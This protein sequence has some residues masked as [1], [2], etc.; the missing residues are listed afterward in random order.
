[1]GQGGG[2][3]DRILPRRPQ[4]RPFYGGI[5]RRS[6]GRYGRP[7]FPPA[8]ARTLADLCEDPPRRGRASRPSSSRVGSRPACPPTRR[9]DGEGASSTPTPLAAERLATCEATTRP[10]WGGFGRQPKFPNAACLEVLMPSEQVRWDQ[11]TQELLLTLEKMWRGGIYDHLRG[12][13]AR[14]AVDQRVAGAALREDAVRQRAAAGACTPDASLRWPEPRLPAP[15]RARDRRATSRADMRGPAGTF[16]AATDAD[17]EGVEGKYFCWTPAQLEAV[18]GSRDDAA[19]FAAVYGV[20]PRGN[21]EHGMSILHLAQPPDDVADGL[22]MTEAALEARLAPLRAKLLAARYQRVPPLRDDKILT[23]W[24]GL[25]ISGFVRAP[26]GGRAVGRARSW[27]GAASPSPTAG[28]GACSPRTSARHGDVMRVD[29]GGDVHTRGYL[30]DLAFLARACLDLHEATLDLALADGGGRGWPATRLAHHAVAGGVGF[31]VTADDAERL[32]E[33][34]ESQHDSA[35]PS[36]LGVMVE[37]LPAARPRRRRPGRAQGGGR[38]VPAAAG[39]GD[40]PAVR[41]RQPDRRRAVRGA[42]G[43]PR[44]PARRLARGGRSSSRAPSPPRGRSMR[45]RLAVSFELGEGPAAAWSAGPRSA[46]RRSTTQVRCGRRCS[47]GLR[48]RP[49]GARPCLTSNTP[50]KAACCS[51]PRPPRTCSSSRGSTR[52]SSSTTCRTRSSTSSTGPG[53][54]GSTDRRLVCPTVYVVPIA[55]VEWEQRLERRVPRSKEGK[56]P[57]RY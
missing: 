6:R 39:R 26:R 45:A 21:F 14:Y 3:P 10:Q 35:I 55:G 52:S 30:E 43:R 34:T 42:R 53:R 27:P 41:V 5:Y 44:H 1:M 46:A 24:N 7:G 4:A 49:R 28:R 19:F 20:D 9:Q 51:A 32:I 22:G 37:V 2:W 57:T 15:G 11:V 29:F 38:G 12:G 40:P 50:A 23:A 13:F 48:G 25:L 18:L 36:G 33:R 31:Y 47:A 56:P 17:S 8:A 54:L 16:Y